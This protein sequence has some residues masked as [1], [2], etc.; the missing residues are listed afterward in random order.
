MPI[1]F[2]LFEISCYSNFAGLNVV[3]HQIRTRSHRVNAKIR[4]SHIPRFYLHPSKS[5]IDQELRLF[6]LLAI[7]KPG[8]TNSLESWPFGFSKL[9]LLGFGIITD[10]SLSPPSLFLSQVNFC[11]FDESAF[12]RTVQ[13]VTLNFT[14]RSLKSLLRRNYRSFVRPIV[15]YECC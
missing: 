8:L 1:N 3:V 4:G 15:G 12:F 10:C 13:Q 14:N 11:K 5:K 9:F 2:V 7:I 6:R